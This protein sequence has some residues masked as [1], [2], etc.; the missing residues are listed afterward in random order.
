LAQ[1]KGHTNSDL[2]KILNAGQKAKP[3]LVTAAFETTRIINAHSIE[4]TAKGVLDLKISHRFNRLDN[5]FSDWFGLDGA[6]MRIG[7]DYGM[8]DWLQIGVGRSSYNKEYDG[9]LKAKILRQ[10]KNGGSPISLSYVGGLS[11]HT[12]K[13]NNPAGTT[14]FFTNR[15]YFFNQLLICKK[16][17]RLLTVQLMPEHVHFNLVPTAAEPNDI[18][19]LGIGGKIRISRRVALNLEYHYQLP[20]FK[21]NGSKNSVSIGADIE[22]GGH[23]FQLHFTNSA[24]MTERTFIAQTADTWGDGGIRFGF[25]I[26]RVFTIVKPKGFENTRNKIY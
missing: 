13:P 17:N 18:L 10:H 21:L 2:E 1:E 20:D 5:G 23:V 14:Y 24:G 26:S 7:F 11:V 22:T 12:L 16:I 15:L 19:A 25:N 4:N 6:T 3:E 9:Y 8:T